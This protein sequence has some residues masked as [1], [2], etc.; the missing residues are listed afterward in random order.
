MSDFVNYDE[1]KCVIL[2]YVN[3]WKKR[4]MTQLEGER[5]ARTYF[6]KAHY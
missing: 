2:A 1:F 6:L 3:E 5:E 4:I